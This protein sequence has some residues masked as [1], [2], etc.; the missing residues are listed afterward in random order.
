MDVPSSTEP[1]A[2][3]ASPAALDALLAVLRPLARVAIDQGVQFGQLEELLKRAMVEAAL[4]ATAGDLRRA[5]PPV[6]RLSVVTGIHRKEVKRLTEHPG[7]EAVQPEPAPAAELFT[8]WMT[9]PV[10]HGPDGPRALPRRPPSDGTPCFEQLARTVT[11][12]VH[13]RTLLDELL[14]LELVSVDGVSD[15]VRLRRESYVPAARLEGMLGFLGA[16]V[17]DH[18]AAAAANVTASL[19]AARDPSAEPARPP[20]VEQALFADGLSPAAA[21]VAA[22]RA[23]EFWVALLRTLAPELQALEDADRATGLVAD[24]RIRI[25]LYCYSEPLPAALPTASVLRHPR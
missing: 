24:Q 25:G 2:G 3:T 19:R 17:G 21:V 18:L 20:F 7:I 11:T 5:A 10:W 23:R 4:R 13:P 14:R 9:D 22:E 8:R 12:D 1:G 15:T 16:N 6:S